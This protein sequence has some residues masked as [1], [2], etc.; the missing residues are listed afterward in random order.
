M[1]WKTYHFD[2]TIPRTRAECV[3]G[4]EI[5]V[6]CEDL[7][8][9]LFP[10]LYREFIDADVEEFDGAISGGDYDLVLVSFGPGEVVEGILCVEP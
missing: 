5:P 10:R 2:R 3:F 9:V 4:Y 1:Q 6:D 8:I 7:S